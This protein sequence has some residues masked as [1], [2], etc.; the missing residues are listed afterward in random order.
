LPSHKWSFCALFFAPGLFGQCLYPVT[1]NVAIGF[2]WAEGHY[3][4]LLALAAELGRRQVA[5]I[6]ATGGEPSPQAVK[7]ATRTIPIVVMA[8]GDP[9][10]AG[11][12]AHDQFRTARTF[13]WW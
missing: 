13:I 5:V 7:A 1:Y 9:V 3:D 11:L 6:A 2:R 10:A 4:R 12:V 8:N